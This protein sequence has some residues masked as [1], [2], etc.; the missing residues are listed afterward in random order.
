MAPAIYF[1]TWC[2]LTAEQ[3]PSQNALTVKWQSHDHGL[4]KRGCHSSCVTCHYPVGVNGPHSYKNITVH[5]PELSS[6]LQPVVHLTFGTARRDTEPSTQ[7]R[8]SHGRIQET[9]AS[10]FGVGGGKP[11]NM[12]NTW[13]SFRTWSFHL[14]FSNSPAQKGE[15]PLLCSLYHSCAFKMSLLLLRQHSP[16]LR[17]SQVGQV[18]PALV[19]EPQGQTYSS[20]V[21]ASRDWAIA[22]LPSPTVCMQPSRSGT[23]SEARGHQCPCPR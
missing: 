6:D 21:P 11:P 7:S 1:L 18:H 20:A 2:L 13:L 8:V 22:L 12:S 3:V 5:K 9:E 4:D 23:T 16:S 17:Q 14:A 10:L 15:P 19:P